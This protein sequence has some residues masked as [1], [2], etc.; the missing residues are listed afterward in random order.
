MRIIR[1]VCRILFSLVFVCAGILKIIDPVGTGLIVKE[2]LSIIH[3]TAADFPAISQSFSA[4][5]PK[6]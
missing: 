5:L 3:V 1:A 2:Y 6:W 4:Y